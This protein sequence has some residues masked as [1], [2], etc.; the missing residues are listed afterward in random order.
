MSLSRGSIKAFH[1]EMSRNAYLETNKFE[2]ILYPPQGFMGPNYTSELASSMT[3]RAESVNLAGRNISSFEE[4]NIYGPV[5]QIPDGVTYGEDI[6]ITF[7]ASQNMAERD[8]LENWQQMI[9]DQ[10]NWDLSYY[11]D[12]IGTI[13]I[14]TISKHNGTNVSSKT[15]RT[16]DTQGGTKRIFETG[17]NQNGDMVR[18]YGIRCQEAWPKTIG[19]SE[20]T[21]AGQAEVLKI[22]AQF[23]YRYWDRIDVTA[24]P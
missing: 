6:S 22:P 3:L 10:G 1:A 9:Y 11:N 16:D 17:N 20:L 23:A 2:V 14:Y 8:Y 7:V 4:S 13:D 5:K 19:A 24:A 21:N 18:T 12:F 15:I